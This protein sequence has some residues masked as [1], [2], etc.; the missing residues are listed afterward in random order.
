M[1]TAEREREEI[2]EASV[3]RD[4]ERRRRQL[5]AE[6]YRFHADQAERLRRTMTGLVE[7]HE[8]EARKL[9]IEPGLS[10]DSMEGESLG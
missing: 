5:E 10:P 6:R 2:W 8:R 4:R 9:L 1:T 7:H 3:R